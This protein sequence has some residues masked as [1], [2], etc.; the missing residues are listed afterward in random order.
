M[1]R[2]PWVVRPLAQTNS[3]DARPRK[4][5]TATSGQTRVARV[6]TVRSDKQSRLPSPMWS[7][8]ALDASLGRVEHV[9]EGVAYDRLNTWVS[10]VA[11]VTCSRMRV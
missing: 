7:A 6:L 10:S 9:L 3:Q 4:A 8:V 5:A 1:D 2:M 11:L